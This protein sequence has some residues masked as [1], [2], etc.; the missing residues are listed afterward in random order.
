MHYYPEDTSADNLRKLIRDNVCQECGR[1]VCAYLDVETHKTYIACSGGRHEGITRE[2]QPP[3]EDYESNIRREIKLEQEQGRATSTALANIPK[4]GQL[5]EVQATKVLSLVYPKATPDEIARCAIFCRDFGLHP[6]ANEVYLIKYGD[7]NMMV[8]GI[9][10]NRKIAHLLKGEFSYLDDSPRAA[11]EEEI[12][13]QFG[14]DS[15]E[16]KANVISITKLQGVSG[17]LAIGFGLYKK[18]EAPKG[19]DKGNTKRNM[20]N[21]RSERQAMD[22]LP[23]RPLPKYEVIDATY[24]EIP[25]VGKVRISTGEII[26]GEATEIPP[27]TTP[28]PTESV[29]TPADG[30]GRAEPPT[31]SPIDLDWLKESAKAIKWSEKTLTSWIAAKFKCTGGLLEEVVAELSPEQCKDLAKQMQDRLEM[32]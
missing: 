29:P 22:R 1:L 9:P 8:V 3:I 17:N 25:D 27:G 5:T 21:I 32:Q 24:A 12:I 28:E 15:D 10:A 2:Y 23:G 30:E 19:I 6:L 26:E 18:S 31:D 7:K 4:Q 16:A 11:T 20:A 14:P 13:K